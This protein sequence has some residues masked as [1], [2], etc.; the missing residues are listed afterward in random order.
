MKITEEI[1]E[2]VGN[3]EIDQGAAMVLMLTSQVEILERLSEQDERLGELED[4][5][6]RYPSITWL[7]K[8][9]KR[10]LIT[11]AIGMALLYTFIFSPWLISDIRHAVLE[12]FGLPHDLGITAPPGG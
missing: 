3:D 6:D 11:V 4:K 9:D 1:K 12:L 8:T 5:V 7:W 10:A 2:L